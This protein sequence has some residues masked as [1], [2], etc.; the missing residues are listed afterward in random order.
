MSSDAA[1]RRRW[2]RILIGLGVLV[3]LFGGAVAVF[4][5]TREG[6]V[7]NPNVEF[8]AEPSP[9]PAPSEAPTK[10]KP[11]ADPFAITWPMY[12]VGED[13]RRYFSVPGNLH[14]PFKKKWVFD[15]GALLEFPPVLQ[16]NSLYVLSDEGVF[17]R[18]DK[19]TGR[20]LYRK[21]LGTLAAATP[22]LA[23]DKVFVTVLT[24]AGSSGGRIVAMDAKT[25]RIEWS[26]DQ[27]SRTESSPLV[28]DGNVYFGTE[29]GMVYALRQS[30]GKQLWTFRAA[31][32]VKGGLALKDG[33]LVFGDYA[34]AAYAISEQTG[35]QIWQAKTKGANFGLR[36]GRFYATPAIA[37][38][39]VYLGNVDGY[40]YSFSLETGQ[41]AWRT[42]TGGYVYASAAIGP[43]PGGRP[44]VFTGSYDGRFY[45]M[46]AQSG[47]TLWT[48]GGGSKISGPAQIL[49]DTV[50]FA[51][52]GHRRVVGLDVRSGKQIFT[53]PKGGFAPVITDGQTIYLTGYGAI[54]ALQPQSTYNKPKPKPR[55]TPDPT[56]KAI[57]AFAGILG[58]HA[59]TNHK[60]H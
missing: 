24:R 18:I 12:G 47:K 43:G 39:R 20:T 60:K 10:G 57:A 45:A 16:D 13:R 15:G 50:Y 25:G 41:L 23:G 49:S 1:P 52:L 37:Y 33:K 29:S 8:R 35:K 31:G 7:S 4:F 36:A 14:G 19:R 5:A 48:Y 9:T 22:A 30:D 3:L 44:S 2:R 58:R 56:Q 28:A 6:N 42:Q 51:D 17:F 26:K 55:A 34:G 27:S 40:V 38:G 46:D 53:Y 54:Y 21:K 59:R 11:A 32:S